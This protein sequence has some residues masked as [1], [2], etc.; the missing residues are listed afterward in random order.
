MYKPMYMLSYN[1]ASVIWYALQHRCFLIKYD[2]LFYY[3][4][5]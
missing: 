5:I 1:I 2:F 4:L 3:N